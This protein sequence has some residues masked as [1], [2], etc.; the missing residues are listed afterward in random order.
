MSDIFDIFDKVNYNGIQTTN[1]LRQV[2]FINDILNKEGVFHPYIVKD[3]ERADSIA[4]DYYGNSS[5]TWLIYAANEIFDPYLDWPLNDR[6]FYRYMNNKYGDVDST[7]NQIMY[8]YNNEKS[9]TK[10]IETFDNDPIEKRVG[11]HPMMVYDFEVELNDRKRHIR[12]LS[13]E[14]LSLVDDEMMRIKKE[15][16]V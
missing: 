7:K 14:Y 16:N 4:F 8:Y 12:L 11:W 1:I 9:Y 2:Y 3:N 13:N 5:Y 6:D 15:L 10:T